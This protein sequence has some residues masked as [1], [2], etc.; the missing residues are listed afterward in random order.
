MNTEYATV[1]QAAEAL[2]MNEQTVYRLVRRGVLPSRRFG[3]IVRIPL[4]AL[5][6]VQQ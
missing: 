6:E 5:S 1:A 3:R 4:A 2:H